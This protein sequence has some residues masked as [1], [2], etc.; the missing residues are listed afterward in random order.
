MENK[1][2]REEEREKQRGTDGLEGRVGE[3]ER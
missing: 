3:I 1:T 2:D